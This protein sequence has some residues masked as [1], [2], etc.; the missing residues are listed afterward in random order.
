MSEIQRTLA[1]SIIRYRPS[2]T[3]FAHIKWVALGE[4]SHGN[5]QAMLEC[6]A[7]S[8]KPSSPHPARIDHHPGVD[9]PDP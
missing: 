5:E 1:D 7:M 8:R 6:H 4:G 2:L 3:L 9:A